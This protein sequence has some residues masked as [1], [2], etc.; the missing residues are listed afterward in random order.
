[1]Q[2]KFILDTNILIRFL[3]N[4]PK[5]QALLV[6]ALFRRAEKKSLMIPDVVLVE[7]VFVLLSVYELAKEEIIE[8]L[9][10]LIVFG[11]FDLHKK[12]F[13]KTL[14]LYSK[15]QISFVDAYVG[16]ASKTKPTR[17]I[18]TFDK[19]ML[20]IKEIRAVEPKQTG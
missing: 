11:R 9:S 10:A 20:K 4:D 3:T 16:A 18:Y 14:G 15:Y 1:M 5:K 13:R 6:E 17:T 12:L 19:R 8:K 7:T 2:G